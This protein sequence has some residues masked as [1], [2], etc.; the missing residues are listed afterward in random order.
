MIIGIRWINSWHDVVKCWYFPPPPHKKLVKISCWMILQGSTLDKPQREWQLLGQDTWTGLCRSVVL[1]YRGLHVAKQR[2]ITLPV[3]SGWT[4]DHPASWTASLLCESGG[5]FSLLV[6]EKYGPQR[7]AF[8]CLEGCL[9]RSPMRSIPIISGKDSE[10]SSGRSTTAPVPSSWSAVPP[11]W[12]WERGRSLARAPRWS[13]ARAPWVWNPVCTTTT[14]KR[15]ACGWTPTSRTVWSIC[16]RWWLCGGATQR[17]RATWTMATSKPR[18]PPRRTRRF[19]HGH[20][21]R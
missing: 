2:L 1:S 9:G 6:R 20:E 8:E 18:R 14:G 21:T 3:R 4:S 19:R 13:E 12:L 10:M 11:C 17:V 15:T 7:R 16:E 5:C